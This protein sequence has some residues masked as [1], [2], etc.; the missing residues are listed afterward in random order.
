[1]C[2]HGG[3]SPSDPG[4][5]RRAWGAELSKGSGLIGLKDR[6]ETL[7][8]TIIGQSAR[9][10]PCV[11]TFRSTLETSRVSDPITWRDRAH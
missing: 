1:M 7:G 9:R 3:R 2:A 6:V 5:G 10:H 4:A 8:D 11:S